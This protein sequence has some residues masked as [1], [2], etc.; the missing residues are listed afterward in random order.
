MS[1]AE[2]APRVHPRIRARRVEVRRDAGRRRLRLVVGAVS[3]LATVASGW[4]LT[5]SAL[6][7]VDR[8]AVTGAGRTDAADVAAAAAVRPGDPMM[9]L[10]M[11]V[12]EARLEQ[13]PWVATATA[14]R[15]WPGV[16]DIAITERRA[17]A[18]VG[19]GDHW[20]LADSSGRVL[21]PAAPDET[22][23]VRVLVSGGEASG[24]EAPVPGQALT[25]ATLGI[26]QLAAAAADT[27][28]DRLDT[29]T[30]DPER[31]AVLSV[32]GIEAIVGA[33]DDIDSKLTALV[34]LLDRVDL[35][36]VTTIDL[37]VPG[38]PVLT[39]R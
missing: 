16:L 25:G 8:I 13:L 12:I 35:R 15:D 11:A 28:G 37:R 3:I 26:V 29:V 19:F 4:A 27:V 31:G 20:V 30:T 10:D 21:A 6:L 24:D 34:T 1:I 18:A 38:A 14:R 36:G 23:L 7:D 33:P 17:V 32:G 2:P 5:R 39:R 9:D 22:G